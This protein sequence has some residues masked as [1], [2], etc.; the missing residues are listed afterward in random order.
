[1]LEGLLVTT[2]G[3]EVSENFPRSLRHPLLRATGLSELN[4]KL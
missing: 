4:T 2:H 1:M 3:G